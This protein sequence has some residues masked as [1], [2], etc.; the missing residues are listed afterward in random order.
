MNGREG[1]SGAIRVIAVV[2]T[3]GLAVSLAACNGVSGVGDLQVTGDA[4]TSGGGGAATGTGASTGTGMATQCDYPTT[5]F[6]NKIGGVIPSTKKWSGYAEHADVV[7]MINISDFYDCDGSRNINALLI[8]ESAVWC[9]ACQDEA[10]ELEGK[11]TGPWADLGIHVLTLMVD[12]A[13]QGA[14][15]TEK[16][17]LT[18]K[19][20]Y[21]LDAGAVG[22]DSNI[23]FAP[24]GQTTIGLPL[25]IL[26]DPRTMKIIEVQ[27]GFSG[28]YSSLEA[29][30]KKNKGM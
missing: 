6:G 12:D 5:G 30:A 10:S 18:W 7:S 15:A 17:A 27:E 25:Q 19:T 3:A 22:V 29:L 4:T 2:V 23:T 28:D 24:P 14:G 13:Q 1:I 9:P 8:D 16:T 20:K 21:K 11:L 26:V